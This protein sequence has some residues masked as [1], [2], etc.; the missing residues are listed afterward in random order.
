M[1]TVVSPTAAPAGPFAALQAQARRAPQAEALRSRRRGQWRS[2]SWQRLAA[3]ADQAARGWAALG[4]LPGDRIVAL[5]P[6]GA[7]LI[8]TLFAA[9]ALG[10]T[11][12]LAQDAA[13]PQ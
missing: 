1:T 5:G 3:Q 13:E 11:V 7:D 10:A 4:A 2:H 6:L 12:V 9:D 8:V